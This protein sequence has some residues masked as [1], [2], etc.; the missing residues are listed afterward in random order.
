[1]TDALLVK[2]TQNAT[3]IIRESLSV[4]AGMEYL[5][6]IYLLVKLVMMTILIIL[7]GVQVLALLKTGIIVTKFLE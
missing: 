2:S 7:T 6:M 1:M 3:Q 4:N 5:T